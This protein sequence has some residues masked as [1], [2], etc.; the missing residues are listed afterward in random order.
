[1]KYFPLEVI[2][3]LNQDKVLDNLL[4]TFSRSMSQDI[5]KEITLDDEFAQFTLTD[6]FFQ[7]DYKGKWKDANDYLMNNKEL[8][9]LILQGIR[10]SDWHQRRT[11]WRDFFGE[12]LVLNKWQKSKV[13]YKIDNEFFHEIKNTGNLKLSR[14]MFKYLPISTMYFDLYD[15][16]D[17][18]DFKGAWVDISNNGDDEYLLAVYMVTD[19]TVSVSQAHAFFSYYC[20]FRFFND[21][22]SELDLK[23]ALT[24]VT[25]TFHISDYRTFDP[26]N[27][28]VIRQPLDKADDHRAEIITAILQILQFLHADIEDVEESPITKSTYRPSV[29]IKNKFSEVRMWDVGVRYGKAIKFAKKQVNEAIKDDAAECV[30]A[31]KIGK[32][33]KPMRPHIR[34]AHWQRYH[35]GEG[36]KQI[37]INWIPPT[38]VCGGRE[39]AV[40]IHKVS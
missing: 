30:E 28:K 5:G 36:R 9:N 8:H 37:K 15:V 32:T 40:T 17:I 39:I 34:S 18:G 21:E 25:D 7:P 27:G 31:N 33:R 26:T 3:N 13:V 20:G 29:V 24:D 12:Y 35:V 16:K 19:S 38:Y 2:D 6:D 4:I 14:P 11:E 1:M 23:E 10:F 22:A